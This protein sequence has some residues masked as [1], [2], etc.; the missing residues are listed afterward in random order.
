MC[1]QS[2]LIRQFKFELFSHELGDVRFDGLAFR[3]ASDNRYKEIVRI[4][5]ILHSSKV[6][7]HCILV[8]SGQHLFAQLGNFIQ[9]VFPHLLIGCFLQ[10]LFQPVL[11]I[12]QTPVFG[13]DAASVTFAEFGCVLLDVLVELVKVDVSQHGADYSTLRSS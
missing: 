1:Y 6:R 5:Y 9:I 11:L 13:I 4:P 3:L 8:R 12:V 10:L 7:I 2:F